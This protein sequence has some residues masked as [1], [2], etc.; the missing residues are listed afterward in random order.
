MFASAARAW[1]HATTA[2]RDPC[3]G[4]F[5][6][7]QKHK[8]T[9]RPEN[10]PGKKGNLTLLRE[11]REKE[12]LFFYFNARVV[13]S[14]LG[15]EFEE[16]ARA[17]TRARASE[18]QS[19]KELQQRRRQTAWR[20]CGRGAGGRA[21]GGLLPRQRRVRARQAL[22]AAQVA[23]LG[24]EVDCRQAAR[25]AEGERGACRE[26]PRQR[27][28]AITFI[29]LKK[30]GFERSP[31]YNTLFFFK[32]CGRFLPFTRALLYLVAAVVGRFHERGAAVAAHPVQRRRQTRARVRGRRRAPG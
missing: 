23:L 28:G 27:L 2:A 7:A 11:K 12:C 19:A 18:V 29:F 30:C 17:G 21:S 13:Y 25:A 22:E 3:V 31:T 6:W 9:R 24:C 5:A 4:S 1:S 8:Q 10:A 14:N 15:G 16:G 20:C 26:Q 32:K